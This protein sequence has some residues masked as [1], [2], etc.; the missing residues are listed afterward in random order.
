MA[1]KV[2]PPDPL[3]LYKAMSKAGLSCSD[4]RVKGPHSVTCPLNIHSLSLQTGVPGGS[5]GSG[6]VNRN[7]AGSDG[8]HPNS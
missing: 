6:T 7:D 8:S 4:A 3:R 2:W 5:R 1:L